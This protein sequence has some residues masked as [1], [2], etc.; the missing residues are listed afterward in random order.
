MG[1]CC[2]R[3]GQP[4]RLGDH[5]C[6]RRQGAVPPERTFGETSR[7]GGVRPWLIRAATTA[8]GATCS[9]SCD[10]CSSTPPPS[11]PPPLPRADRPGAGHP[12]PMGP[13][14][15]TT[16]T[17]RARA[18]GS[19][20]S[21]GRERIVRRSTADR[22][23]CRLATRRWPRGRRHGGAGTDR[24]GQEAGGTKVPTFPGEALCAQSPP[25]LGR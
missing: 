1:K 12:A 20:C 10:P 23:R 11:P 2:D 4:V 25:C 24:A 14:R 13:L 15:A 22:H 16:P 21:T 7:Q 9:S 8:S 3:L 5:G 17:R 19:A 6:L 18:V